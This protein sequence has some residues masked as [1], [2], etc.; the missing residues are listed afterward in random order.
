MKPQRLIDPVARQ[1]CIVNARGD[2]A[3]LGNADVLGDVGPGVVEEG[4][5]SGLGGG[6]R[7]EGGDA[8]VGF[9]CEGAPAG[10]GGEGCG[11]RV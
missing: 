1:R 3:V 5:E 7:G 9:C 6:G 4:G 8:D 2:Q 11:A 10:G